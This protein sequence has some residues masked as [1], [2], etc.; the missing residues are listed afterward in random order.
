MDAKAVSPE[1]C[2]LD[3]CGAFV[4]GR[5]HFIPLCIS[6]QLNLRSKYEPV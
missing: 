6:D 4:P 5:Y 2:K 3:K 1:N